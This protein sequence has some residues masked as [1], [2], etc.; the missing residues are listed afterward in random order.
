MSLYHEAAAILSNTESAG[1]SLKS[2]IYGTKD[3]KNSQ[4]QIYALASETT[5]W[6]SVLK[7]VLEKTELLQMERKVNRRPI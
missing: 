2:R 4:A 6:S 1:G 5:K 3:T 7:V